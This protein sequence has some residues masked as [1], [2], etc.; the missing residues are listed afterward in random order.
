MRTV[1]L[2]TLSPSQKS[3]YDMLV[4]GKSHDEISRRLGL[5]PGIL[6]AQ[7]TRIRNRQVPLPGDADYQKVEAIASGSPTEPTNPT[8]IDPTTLA[9][10]VPQSRPIGTGPSANDQIAAE[11]RGRALNSDELAEL[12]KKVGGSVARDV[13][14]MI[15]MGTTIQFVRMCGG[16]MTAHQVI[17]DV[18][19][20]LRAFVGDGRTVPGDT[21]GETKPMPQTDQERM[22]LQD[23]QITELREQ[24]KRLQSQLNQGQYSGN[25][26]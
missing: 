19:G 24:V 15:L 4:D 16:R 13:H 23:E 12:A 5:G 25:R 1:D 2:T 21:G 11:L 22:A 17:E 8:H 18:Y 7:M 26:Y 14:P 20:A 6:N 3:I 9:S 10:A